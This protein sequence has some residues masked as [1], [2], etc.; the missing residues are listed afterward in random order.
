MAWSVIFH[1]VFV[2]QVKYLCSPKR[3]DWH[4]A[5]SIGVAVPAMRLRNS[6]CGQ[7]VCRLNTV[8]LLSLLQYAGKLLF[9]ILVSAQYLSRTIIGMVSLRVTPLSSTTS[10]TVYRDLWFLWAEKYP[11]TETQVEGDLEDRASILRPNFLTQGNR[12]VRKTA[13]WR[14]EAGSSLHATFGWG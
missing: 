11:F 8:S 12:R 10:S 5:L 7:R 4:P 1:P 3:L 13:H 6:R 9:L 14:T 2:Y